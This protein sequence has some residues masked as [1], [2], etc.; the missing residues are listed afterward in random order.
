MTSGSGARG[1]SSH[2]R[3][4]RAAVAAAH[5]HVAFIYSNHSTVSDNRIIAQRR[6]LSSS[7][8]AGLGCR[9]STGLRESLGSILVVEKELLC[10]ANYHLGCK[11]ILLLLAPKSVKKITI[12]TTALPLG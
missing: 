7:L 10:S 11:T 5:A 1:L 8:V 3:A 12:S 6:L 9:A 4:A 2:R